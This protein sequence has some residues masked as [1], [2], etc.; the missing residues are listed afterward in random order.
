MTLQLQ[1]VAQGQFAGYYAAADQGY[2][3]DAGLDVTIKEGGVDIVPQTVLAQGQADYAIAWV[4]KALASREQ[5]ASI[6]DVAQVYQRSG[7]RQVS[8]KTKNITQPADFKGKKIGNWGFG[9][10]FELFAG[11]TQAGLKPASDVTLV[12][13]QFDMQ[14]FLKG[15]IDAAQAM[16]YNEYAQVLEAKNPATG[17]LYQ[18]T[19]FNVI[20]WNDD[21]TAMLQ[22][23][24]WA[25][26]DKL[27]DP[28]YQDQT[29]KFVAAS[30]KGWIYCRDHVGGVPR[31]RRQGRVEA[32]REPPAVAGQR[33]QQA[34][35][36]VAVGGCRDDRP[37]RV[38]ADGEGGAHRGQR[39]RADRAHEGPRRQGLHQ[40]LRHQG[41]RP[42][43]G[44]GPRRRGLRVQAGD[45]HAERGR[46]LT[47]R[48]RKRV[49]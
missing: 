20:N 16:S 2:Y 39:R 1:W 22:D 30:L 23:A 41:H 12:Q 21:G 9:N 17:Q 25:N 36:A 14:A 3:K 29:V 35:L 31:H 18:P 26:T 4:P 47:D 45:G 44:C 40:R 42:V 37:G 43:E 48:A 7:T 10:E 13:Q 11:M 15:D 27:S 32:R 38:D 24:I 46:R 6:T 28:A 5:G 19:D 49:L 34:D 33:G 8:F